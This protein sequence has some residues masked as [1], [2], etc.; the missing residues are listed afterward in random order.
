MAS[1]AN[2]LGKA[3]IVKIKLSSS[4][5][6]NPVVLVKGKVLNKKTNEPLEAIIYYYDMD[7]KA[8]VGSAVSNPNT[9]QY[10][11]ILQSGKKYSFRANKENFYAINDFLDV[12][13]LNI[14]TETEKNLYLAPLEVGQTIRLNNIFFDVNK[15]VLKPHSSEELDRLIVLLKENPKMEIEISGHTDNQGADEYNLTLSQQRVE[16][17]LVY[18][19]SKGIPAIRLKGK[20]HGESKAIASNETEE[21]RATN[22]RVDFTILKQ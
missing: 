1:Y 3:D 13:T 22:R 2:S 12:S 6:P 4:A 7:T 16:S 21:G 17:V 14:Y 5:K 9:G 8:E 20:G 18:L 11:I 19:T 10:N 15:A